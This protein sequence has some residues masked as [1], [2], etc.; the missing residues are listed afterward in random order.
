MPDILHT[1]DDR[2]A[3]AIAV[4]G[5]G[6][7]LADTAS[8]ANRQRAALVVAYLPSAGSGP[9]DVLDVGCGDGSLARAVAG[10]GHRVFGCDI[11]PGLIAYH[12]RASP[13][14]T[15]ALCEAGRPLPYPDA[16]FDAIVSSEVIEHVY[17][18]AGWAQELARCLKPQGCLVLTTP[19]HGRLKVICL[20]A[21]GYFDRHFNPHGAHI[22][23]FTRRSLCALLASVGL[24]PA[25]VRNFGR[26]WPV[27]KG[28][29]VTARKEAG[30]TSADSLAGVRPASRVGGS[31]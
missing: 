27:W 11:S 3:R 14:G 18:V 29:L 21:L 16:R 1:H 19:Y 6:Q 17:D 5:P 13:W 25:T 4:L 23:F 24:R 9:L 2:W 28:M 7:H 31:R 10:G 8:P 12:R 22:R 20:A 30:N 26:F 15:F